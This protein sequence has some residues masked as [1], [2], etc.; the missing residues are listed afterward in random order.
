MGKEKD[1]CEKSSMWAE[2]LCFN[3][4]STP[5]LMFLATVTVTGLKKGENIF[6]CVHPW[7][8]YREN[9][10]PA[11]MNEILYLLN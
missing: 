1:E 3:F 10:H 7:M 9:K 11:R 6:I 2:N 4:I 5:M 8:N